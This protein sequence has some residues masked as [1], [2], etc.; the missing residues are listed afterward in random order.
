MLGY[1]KHIQNHIDVILHIL[2]YINE[3]KKH[4]DC[5]K[6]KEV[7]MLRR[8]A[9]MINNQVDIFISYPLSNKTMRKKFAE[10]DADV[11]KRSAD[12]YERSGELSHVLRLLRKTGFRFYTPLILMS[13]IRNR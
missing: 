5:D 3:Y 6:L 2:D 1:Q 13:K 4:S 10:F 7:Y 8:I 11:K 9:D 12:V